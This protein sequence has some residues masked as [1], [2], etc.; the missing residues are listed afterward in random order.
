MNQSISTA[1]SL[2]TTACSAYSTAY[3]ELDYVRVVLAS[4]GVVTAAL[5]MAVFASRDMRKRSGTFSFLLAAA[6]NDC[7]YLTALVFNINFYKFCGQSALQCGR[8]GQL[9]AMT[10]YIGIG[11]W[12]TSSSAFLNICIEI[13]LSLERLFMIANRRFHHVPV[14]RFVAMFAALSLLYYLP[15][16]FMYK[17]VPCQTQIEDSRTTRRSAPARPVS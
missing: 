3:S 11:D 2:N 4:C 6:A 10:V 1:T 7:F 16:V 14:T 8:T 17:F 5:N 15:M 13:Y 9:I 12:L